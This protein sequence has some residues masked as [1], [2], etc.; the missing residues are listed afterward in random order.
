[1]K[2]TVVAP[3]ITPEVEE[4]ICNAFYRLYEKWVMKQYG[5]KVSI[6]RCPAPGATGTRQKMGDKNVVHIH[7]SL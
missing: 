3:E 2:P 6:E 7:S 1:M 4:V 5:V